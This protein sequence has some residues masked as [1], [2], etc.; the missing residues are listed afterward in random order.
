[1]KLKQTP[2]VACTGTVDNLTLYE[3]KGEVIGRI[4][5]TGNKHK[6]QPAQ[7]LSASNMA[8]SAHL[9]KMFPQE[10][11]PSFQFLQPGQNHYNRF[12]SFARHT[13]P[14]YLVKEEVESLSAVVVPVAVSDGVLPPIA[15]WW[16]ADC[17]VT[18]LSIGPVGSAEGLT[19]RG[20]TEALLSRNGGWEEGDTLLFYQV[21]QKVY[22]EN[23]PEPRAQ[24]LAAG[25]VLNLAD[26]RP[27]EEVARWAKGFESVEGRLAHT[28]VA[29]GGVAWVHL[30][31][32]EKECLRSPQRLLCRNPLIERYSTFERAM[33]V[34]KSFHVKLE[35]PFLMPDEDLH[36][37]CRKW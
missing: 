24:V 22:G 21:L 26:N 7:C 2:Y 4:H 35:R 23:P 18:D 34:W 17:A 11:K 29:D 1:M 16:E 15:A 30:R 33:E 31:K 6:W 9:Y 10:W 36:I 20:L 14:V 32:T 25:V 37:Y 3:R 8:N 28:A 5:S 27:L 13:P 19:V 12:L